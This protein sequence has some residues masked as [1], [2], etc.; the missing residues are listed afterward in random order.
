MNNV[1][2]E[3]RLLLPYFSQDQETITLVFRY[4]EAFKEML[5]CMFCNFPRYVMP[6]WG[7]VTNAVR[8][9]ASTPFHLTGVTG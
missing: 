9:N 3:S 8:Y 1:Q 2:V 7:V 5:V 4:P 6:L